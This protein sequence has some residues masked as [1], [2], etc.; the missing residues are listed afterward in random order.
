MIFPVLH[1]PF[2]EDGTIQGLVELAN[3]PCVGPNLLSSAMCMDKGIMKEI[4]RARGLSSPHHL[5]LHQTD[6]IDEKGIIAEFTLPLFVKPAQMGSSVGVSKVHTEEE[7]L[8]AIREAFKYDERILIEEYIDGRE[9]ECSVLGNEDPE[10]S[11]P[12][13]IITLHKFYSYE[14]KYLDENGAQFI[15]PAKIGALKTKEVKYLA[16]K[17]FKALR[18]EGMA[19]IDFFLKKDGTLLINELNTIPG[20]TSISLYPNL[21][22]ISGISYPKLIDCLIELSIKRFERKKSFR[23]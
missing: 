3:L 20:F 21:W 22:E 4:L 13:E 11:L 10:A 15:L 17:A 9:I 14:A 6:P 8:P 7:L 12:G 1:G 16:I 5:T 19:R 18:C 2:G 23:K